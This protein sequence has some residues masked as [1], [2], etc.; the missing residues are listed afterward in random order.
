[1]ATKLDKEE[2]ARQV[3]TLLAVIGKQVNKVFRTFT[4]SS[5]DDAKKIAAVVSKFEEYCI[6]RENTIY[7]R[8]LFFTRDQRESETVDQYLME[9]RQIA[10]NCDFESVTPD[11]LLRDRLVTGTKTAK[12]RENLLK[13]KKLTLEK[14]ID[15]ACA[16]ESTAVQMKVMS[17]ESGLSAVKEKEKEQS[18]NVPSVSSGWIKDCRFCGRNHE[19]CSCPAFGQICAYCKKKNHFVA[20]C[21]A[22]RKVS[23]VQERFYLSAAGIG[24]GGHEMVTLTVSKES[25]PL[26]G[27]DVSF[28]MDTRAECN[29]L[30][31]DVYKKVTGDLHLNFLSAC[32][33]L[34]LV[35]ANGDEQPIE[36][37]ATVYVSR[38]GDAHKIEVNVVRGH[39]Y[40]P[41]LSKQTMLQMN[42]I[43]ILDSD[44][45]PCVNVLTTDTEPLLEEY[46]DVFEGLGKLDG[47]YHIVTDE[48]IRPVVHPPRRLPVAMTERVQRNLEEMAAANI[49]EQVDQPTDWVS[50]MLVVSK[51]ST[52]AEGETKLRICLDPRDLNLAIK[53]EHFPM[54]TIE[55]I[56]TRLNGAK[57]FS[58]FDASNGFWQVELAMSLVV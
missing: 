26:S 11:Q 46:D 31:L 9:L 5:P 13:E 51:P 3:A 30:P 21:P 42:L 29:L 38:K 1:M 22:K 32:S 50:S 16:A 56:A 17:A 2:E 15:I 6:P 19:R 41:I 45:D 36:G 34:V 12:V 23:T 4:W 53:R 39:G 43:K 8:F 57:L 40:E 18:E 33:K 35:L 55:E 25:K 24:N 52:E 10:A 20:K 49:I 7:K 54:P 28:L 47:Q 58:V 44:R 14:A 37:K 27:H 48:S